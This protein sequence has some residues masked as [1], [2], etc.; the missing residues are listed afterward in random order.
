M[1]NN[2]LLRL[3]LPLLL[4][5]AAGLTACDTT[6]N[7][8]GIEESLDDIPNLNL[9]EGAESVVATVN[10]DRNK[11]N[12]TIR[13]D[14]MEETSGISKGEYPAFCALWDVAIDSNN[15]SYG[16]VKLHSIDNE[17]YWKGVNY[18]V[19]NI[20]S[21]EEQYEDLS[22]LEIQIALWSIMDHKKFD[23]NTIPDNELPSYVRD[24]SYDM[25]IINNILEDV[26]DN[27]DLI[28]PGNGCLQIL[29]AEVPG[30]Q[31]QIIIVPGE[32]PQEKG[33]GVRYRNFLS[34]ADQ[35]EI[36]LGTGDLGVGANRSQEHATFTQNGTTEIDF[37]YSP[38]LDQ[39]SASVGNSYTIYEDLSA[40]MPDSCSIQDVD[41]AQIWV[42]ARDPGTTVTLSGEY[43]GESISVT[44]DYDNQSQVF[45]SLQN[46]D[47]SNGFYLNGEITLSGTFTSGEKGKA[48][49]VFGCPVQL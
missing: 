33:F 9:I 3:A 19:N 49:I 21:Y 15:G 37:V 16:N 10:R 39:L 35:Q 45:Y 12:F 36:Y 44:A 40:K 2:K 13:L 27:K 18:L 43:A 7:V 46:L 42:T 20:E 26:S 32:C 14:G 30:A 1:L 5:I 28:L 11:S 41:R 23:L 8:D 34:S 47:L 31:D 17:P 4:L 48:E 29:Y 6:N 25:D 24:G 22:W 38:E